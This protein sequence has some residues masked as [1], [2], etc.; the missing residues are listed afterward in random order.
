MTVTDVRKDTDQLTMS[1]T[2]EYDAPVEQVWELWADPRL[3]ER[4]WGPP[5]YPATFV[6]HDLTVG[7]TATYYMTGPEG[8]RHHGWWEFVDIDA[9]STLE[10]DDGFADEA[11]NRSTELPSVR[12]RVTIT[13]RDGGGALMTIHTTFPSVEAMEQMV[14]MGMEDGMREALG[15]TD[16]L[17]EEHQTA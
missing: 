2:V 17:L 9:P 12:M 7:G 5:T 16:V 8:Q 6:D 4:W 1:I 10:L 14:Q 15:Q 13:G 11:G 3:L